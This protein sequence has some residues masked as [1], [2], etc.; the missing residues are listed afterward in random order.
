MSLSRFSE[1]TNMSSEMLPVSVETPNVEKEPGVSE[2]DE[3]RHKPR[4]D[5]G[6]EPI[7]KRQMKKLMKQKQWEEQRELRRFVLQSVPSA[8]FGVP[9]TLF[10]GGVSGPVHSCLPHNSS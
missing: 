10:R 2:G 6:T 4:L 8:C 5:A 3:E 9:C 7:S 1:T